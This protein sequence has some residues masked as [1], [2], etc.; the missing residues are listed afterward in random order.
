MHP[1]L[2]LHHITAQAVTPDQ[3]LPYVGAVSAMR[4][5]LCEG[6]V[7]HQHEGRAVLV[8]YPLQ[9]SQGP[10]GLQGTGAPNAA[11]DAALDAA[12]RDGG[13]RH[14]TVLAATR[15][16][17]AP[18]HAA[19]EEDCYWAVPLPPAPPAQK[20]RHMLQCAAREVVI[21]PGTGVTP[22]SGGWSAE[23]AGLVQGY[24]NSRPLEPGTRHIFLHLGHYLAA[25]PEA[26]LW[27]ARDHEGRLQGCA[28]GDY[29]ALSTAFYMFAFRL[30]TAPPGVADSLLAAVL[31]EGSR[32]GHA[33][34]NLGLGINASIAFFKKKWR[35]TPFLPCVQTSWD[36]R[37]SKKSW[38]SR[39]FSS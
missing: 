24:I 3:L 37:S 19:V 38:F 16:K 15:P 13:I 9:D 17:A 23:H 2:S 28:I 34:C 8:G 14:M 20:L 10:Q 11:L 21:T 26:V 12:L 30:P 22:E 4:S 6:C 36:V 31:D 35:A 7:L 18:E 32:R 39:I 5:T 29:S 25:A 27:S 33:Q 1:G